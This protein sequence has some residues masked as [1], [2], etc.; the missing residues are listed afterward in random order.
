MSSLRKKMIEDLRVRNYSPRTID[1]YV[2]C[3]ASFARHF[4]KSPD[5]LGPEHIRDYQ[6]FLVESKRASWSLFNQT[7]CALRF[8]YKVSLGKKWVI[9]HIPFPRQEKR[10]PVIPSVREL[11]ALFNAVGNVKHRTV[12]MTM[13]AAG[14]RISEAMN[15]QISDI[16]SDRRL[17]RIR[18]GKGKRD[19]YVPLSSTLLNI[20]REYWKAYRPESWLFPGISPDQP[21]SVSSVQ[22]VC[23]IA[24]RKARL[25]KRVTTHTMRH[26]FATHLLEAGVDLRTIQLLLGHQSLST[27]TVYLHVATRALKSTEGPLDLLRGAT[28]VRENS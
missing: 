21:L 20:L 27:T 6:L 25:S 5:K 1:T 22:R 4:G 24:Q 3:V 12:L 8:F 11:K 14:L 16:D 15:L 9:G 28:E 18:Q 19:R 17:V 23:S 10:L 26:C 13:Y 2:R 7:V